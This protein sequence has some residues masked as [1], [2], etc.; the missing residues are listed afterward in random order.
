MHAFMYE[1]VVRHLTGLTPT[2]SMRS[3]FSGVCW[4]QNLLLTTYSMRLAAGQ[5]VKSSLSYCW[6]RDTRDDKITATRGIY[7]KFYHELAGLG[8]DAAF[9][10]TEAEGQLS[11]RLL[12]GLVRLACTS[13]FKFRFMALNFA[14]RSHSPH[15]RVSCGLLVQERAYSRTGSSWEDPPVCDPSKRTA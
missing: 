15:E 10:K 1:A 6:T 14:R 11:R 2:A 3:V 5:T 13:P 7:A 12:P 4:C 8:G 9:S